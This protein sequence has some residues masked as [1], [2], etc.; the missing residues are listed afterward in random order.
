MGRDCSRPCWRLGAGVGD[1][2]A[3]HLLA[4]DAQLHAHASDRGGLLRGEHAAHVLGNPLG[5]DLAALGDG[6][7]ERDREP[8]V[9]DARLARRVG[10]DARLGDAGVHLGEDVHDLGDVGAALDG[11]GESVGTGD[12]V[13]LRHGEP[14]SVSGG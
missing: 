3:V 5:G 8:L 14:L 2:A 11:D 9:L 4:Q 12:G 1:L 13:L 10:L 7:R 6:V